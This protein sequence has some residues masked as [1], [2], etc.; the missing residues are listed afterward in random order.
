MGR[1]LPHHR[2]LLPEET[3]VIGK[4]GSWGELCGIDWEEL[5]GNLK[6]DGL[7][8]EGL[9]K[10]ERH[11]IIRVEE[12]FIVDFF[13]WRIPLYFFGRITQYFAI[14]VKNDRNISFNILNILG[15]TFSS[16]V[17]GLVF[18]LVFEDELVEMGSADAQFMGF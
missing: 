5:R 15:M 7:L 14:I 10:L 1:L 13:G 12:W 4:D 11:L 16:N 3:K 6:L 8:D 9:W 18:F 17:V 2:E